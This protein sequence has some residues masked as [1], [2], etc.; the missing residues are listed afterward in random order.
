MLCNAKP[1][2][3]WKR[4]DQV[5]NKGKEDE[6]IEPKFTLLID[7]TNQ[8][9]SACGMC[10]YE[11][12]TKDAYANI[13]E[14]RI[15]DIMDEKQ[16]FLCAK[17]HLKEYLANNRWYNEEGLT[18]TISDTRKLS[19]STLQEISDLKLDLH[20]WGEDF[21]YLFF[22]DEAVR[23]TKDGAECVPYSKMLWHLPKLLST[24][25]LHENYSM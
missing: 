19:L 17:G 5:R 9:L 8:L 15:V 7:R 11:G 3:F 10:K 2:M 1:M 18:D 4:K 6:F 20:S 13:G 12:G 25:S 23:V 14:D 22:K 24:D 21:D 16:A